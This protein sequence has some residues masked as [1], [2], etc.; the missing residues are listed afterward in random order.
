MLVTREA[1][2][3]AVTVNPVISRAYPNNGGSYPLRVANL[4]PLGINFQDCEANIELVYSLGITDPSPSLSLEAWAGTECTKVES[5]NPTTAT[6]WPLLPGNI[7]QVNPATARIRVRDVVAHIGDATKQ[8]VYSPASE[9]AC[10]KQTTSGGTVVGIY[11][12]YRDASNMPAGTAAPKIDVP[13]DVLGPSP[14]TNVSV[15]FGDTLIKA[16]WTAPNDKDALSY[17]VYCDPPRGEEAT[18]PTLVVDAGTTEKL[19]CADA[20]VSSSTDAGS[21]A[22][23]GVSDAAVDSGCVTVLVPNEA[24]SATTCPSALLVSGGGTLTGD[25]DSGTRTIVG[26]VQKTLDPKYKCGSAGGSISGGSTVDNLVN[27]TNYT[28]AVAGTDLFGNAG[29][30]SNP[31]CA[32][33]QL[34]DDFWKVY[35]R[36]GGGA[37]GGFC[38]LE[39]VGIPAGTGVFALGMVAAMVGLLRRRKGS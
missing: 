33:P 14:P 7:V 25:A 26:G 20:A 2:A 1:C 22:S 36:D 24:G 6:C 16:T 39:G 12:F 10:H 5:R 38:A 8:V 15:L 28:V 4:T 32:T 18:G 11:F 21:D 17:D 9:A 13:V 30:L 19:V 35:R 37:G 23:T 29:P 27:G 3:Q 31:G 34:I